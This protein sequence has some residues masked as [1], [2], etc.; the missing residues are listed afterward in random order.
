MEF[1][2]LVICGSEYLQ[3]LIYKLLLKKETKQRF[4]D[5]VDA[6]LK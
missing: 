3:D 4:Q 1:E 5:K 6:H 2:S